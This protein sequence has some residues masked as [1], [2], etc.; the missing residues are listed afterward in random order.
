MRGETP[1]GGHRLRG[2]QTTFRGRQTTETT[3]QHQLLPG[4]CK[5]AND[6]YVSGSGRRN[7]SVVAA[8]A[9]VAHQSDSLPAKNSARTP[10]SPGCRAAGASAA[11][12]TRQAGRRRHSNVKHMSIRGYNIAQAAV[13][14]A[15]CDA[16]QVRFCT[17]LCQQLHGLGPALVVDVVCERALQQAD[18][19]VR[20]SRGSRLLLHTGHCEELQ[21]YNQ[22]RH[23]PYQAQHI[24]GALL[25]S[26]QH[27]SSSSLCLLSR[28]SNDA[29]HLLIHFVML[30]VSFRERTQAPRACSNKCG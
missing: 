3:P 19:A 29:L 4:S 23:A 9:V 27:R 11:T 22:C 14:C 1:G 10:T 17:H 20:Q 6:V 30:M 16:V 24:E 8:A 5:A 13:R 12:C 2:R 7:S 26:F 15:L 25:E 28:A 18:L 21:R